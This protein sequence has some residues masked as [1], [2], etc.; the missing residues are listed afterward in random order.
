MSGMTS[1]MLRTCGDPRVHCLQKTNVSNLQIRAEK[2]LTRF[3]DQVMVTHP[4]RRIAIYAHHPAQATSAT[5]A[6]SR[7][8]LRQEGGGGGKT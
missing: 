6:I 1:G 7:R 4:K 3:N 5:H 8:Q 2:E